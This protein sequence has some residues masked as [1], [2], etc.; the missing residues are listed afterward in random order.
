MKRQ[1]F[2]L[3]SLLLAAVAVHAASSKSEHTNDAAAFSRLKTLAG[4]WE[5]D[6]AMGKAHLSYEVIAGGTALV[7]K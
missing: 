2:V 4:E 5:A 1:Y 6:T 7:E 3:A